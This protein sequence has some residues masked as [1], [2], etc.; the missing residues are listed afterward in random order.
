MTLRAIDLLL[1]RK[2]TSLHGMQRG[3]LPKIGG[4]VEWMD[5]R[6]SVRLR[7]CLK[8]FGRRH[9]LRTV[10]DFSHLNIRLL[11][12]TENFGRQCFLEL[13][14]GLR[15][16]VQEFA[17]NRNMCELGDELR[18]LLATPYCS[19]ILWN[20]ARFGSDIATLLGMIGQ[21][22]EGESFCDKSMWDI[23]ERLQ[24]AKLRDAQAGG[25]H[26]ALHRIRQRIEYA[27][28][29][30]LEKELS[31]VLN[32]TLSPRTS[33]IVAHVFGLDGAGGRTPQQAAKRFRLTPERI[34]QLCRP[35]D[36]NQRR[37]PFVPVLEKCVELIST[38]LPQAAPVLERLIFLQGLTAKPFQLEGVKRAADLFLVPSA[39]GIEITCDRWVVTSA[40]RRSVPRVVP[41]VMTIVNRNGVCAITNVAQ[42]LNLPREFVIQILDA[43]SSVRWLTA[44][45][46]WILL[47]SSVEN[48]LRFILRKVA[49]AAVSVGLPELQQAVSR[50]RRAIPVPP[51][52]VLANFCRELGWKVNKEWVS[53]QPVSSEILNSTEQKIVRI[54][55]EH[56]PTLLRSRIR[57]LC[58]NIGI[59]PPTFSM[60]LTSNP[61][62][63]RVGKSKYRLIGSQNPCNVYSD[64][65]RTLQGEHSRQECPSSDVEG[66]NLWRATADWWSQS[67]EIR[68]HCVVY[69]GR[70]APASMPG[71]SL[72]I[73]QRSASMTIAVCNRCGRKFET[74][75]PSRVDADWEL[76]V[77][78]ER[79]KCAPI[80]QKFPVGQ[81]GID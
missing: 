78:F 13:L 16:F 24:A 55:R 23:L 14:E 53:T 81:S 80:R 25:A 76:Q 36:L 41:T 32:G 50:S 68:P 18:L 37:R 12:E 60:L 29:L 51:K 42:S 33:L 48:R 71:T 20:D 43:N 2:N 6:W 5:L 79:H 17:P 3:Q 62:I 45:K 56:G 52:D 77:L 70:W 69:L 9:R 44:D 11:F 58:F 22:S 66:H 39:V 7:N 10:A 73:V 59:T 47:N 57:Q 54:F 15:P 1:E 31:E 63:E 21:K 61:L 28:Q 26:R 67:E 74:H 35:Q 30:P 75:V 19:R 4:A 64:R 65:N 72:R 38:N 8:K 49:A 40:M 27:V 34:R 46:E